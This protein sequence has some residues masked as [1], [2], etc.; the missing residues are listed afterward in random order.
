MYNLLIDLAFN[1]PHLV[2]PSRLDALA[3]FLLS[4]SGWDVQV[5]EQPEPTAFSASDRAEW[6]DNGYWLE[7]G[8]AVLD[9]VGTL[10]HKAVGMRAL[11]GV[12]S[13]DTISKRFD[14]AMNDPAARAILLNIDS[15]GGA[16][17]GAFDLSDKIYQARGIKPVEALASDR[18]ASAA[19][20]IGSAADQVHA[21]Q[22]AQIGSIG[23]VMKHLDISKWNSKTGLRPTYIYAGKRKV[24]G[25]MD[26]ALS[27]EVE[28]RFQDKINTIYDMF[29]DA[30]ERHRGMDRQAIIDTE[31]EVF[32]G[33]EAVTENLADDVTTGEALLERMKSNYGA[34]VPAKPSIAMEN[35]TMSITAEPQTAAET[36]AGT[37]T[38]S[39]AEQAAAA[40]DTRETETNVRLNERARIKAILTSDAAN[41][42]MDAA[43]VMATD[44]DMPEAGAIEALGKMP[45]VISTP[46]R[47]D[48]LMADEDQPDLE[49][50]EATGD[51][52]AAQTI[53][54]HYN[55]ATGRKGA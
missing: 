17:S 27:K 14:R 39:A 6:S 32:M 48:A 42:R 55:A 7:D 30:V 38:P 3:A 9:M 23:V 1:Q 53:L 41:G 22:T 13:Y 44:T 19:F 18:M 45:A 49:S 28:A 8:V 46:S 47:L 36:E 12:T 10:V 25:N 26:E 40:A 21:T 4:E 29:V 15:P 35:Q 54:G 11:S 52:S 16:V 50:D 33:E 37:D 24:D 34:G 2:L 31:A 43:I 5:P 51:V 20:L